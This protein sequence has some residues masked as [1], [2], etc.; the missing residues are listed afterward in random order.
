MPENRDLAHY[1]DKHYEALADERKRYE[2]GWRRA[3]DLLMPSREF[4]NQDDWGHEQR[5]GKIGLEIFNSH[6]VY[7]NRLLA[8]GMQGN[9]ISPTFIFFRLALQDR[10]LNDLPEV[11]EW[12]EEWERVIYS[13]Y[14]QSNYYA[15]MHKAFMDV[16]WSGNVV[17]T[18]EEDPDDDGRLVWNT[19][20]IFEHFLSE[21]PYGKVDTVY[22]RYFMTARNMERRWSKAQLSKAVRQALEDENWEKR[23][24][25]IQAIEPR[26]EDI[27]GLSARNP[28]LKNRDNMPYVTVYKEPGEDDRVLE[29]TG[30]EAAP[31]VWRWT[32]MSGETYGRGPGQWALADVDALNQISRD[33]L[34]ASQKQIDPPLNVPDEM[35]DSFSSDPGARNYFGRDFRRVAQPIVSSLN[36]QVGLDREQQKMDIINKHFHTEFFLIISQADREK[37]A[38]EVSAIQEEKITALAPILGRLRY[39]LLDAQIDRTIAILRNQGKLPDPPPSLSDFEGQPMRILYEGPMA[40]A[41]RRVFQQ[42]GI[43]EWLLQLAELAQIDPRQAENVMDIPDLDEIA[44]VSHEA[45]N[46]SERIVRTRDEV[47]AI[48]QARRQQLAA[49]MQQQA[50]I[51]AGQANKGLSTAPEAGSPAEA[52]AGAAGRENLT[53]PAA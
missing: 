42:A 53:I 35:W 6:A 41:Q 3:A 26:V 5:G 10:E 30:R 25:I 38:R 9:I 31:L 39:D 12:L 20:H 52:L 23:F 16:G 24:P 36:Y 43:R 44:Y 21:N 7:A 11:K 28:N 46:L 49:Q 48:R 29:V 32:V 14:Q 22:R 34:I 4:T 33:L 18:V 27:P 17:Q 50:L 19:N 40:V 2:E 15:E 51:A 8:D 37:T 1:V 13:A 45:A 47:E